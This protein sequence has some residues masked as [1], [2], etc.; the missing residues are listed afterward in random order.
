MRVVV[1]LQSLVEPAA[2]VSTPHTQ[3]TV[4]IPRTALHA[5]RH[6]QS[7]TH[8]PHGAHQ[9]HMP[10]LAHISPEHKHHKKH[11]KKHKKHSHEI[12]A[13][14][15]TL[16]PASHPKIAP[17]R[18]P[19]PKPDPPLSTL[20]TDSS[21]SH[22]PHTTHSKHH[23]H[24]HKR[25]RDSLE[26]QPHG[27]TSAHGTEGFVL[28]KIKRP[29]IEGL[30]FKESQPVEPDK[31]LVTPLQIQLPPEVAHDSGHKHKKKKKK[32]KH[33]KPSGDD[34]SWEIKKDSPQPTPPQVP[35]QPSPSKE[36]T[37][38]APSLKIT[39]IKIA[40]PTAQTSPGKQMRL[41]RGLESSMKEK[42]KSQSLQGDRPSR[43]QSGTGKKVEKPV[44]VV[45]LTPPPPAALVRTKTPQGNCLLDWLITYELSTWPIFLN[46]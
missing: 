3:L 13:H 43:R 9:L 6:H 44:E 34:V 38:M 22:T 1:P 28:P 39:P 8:Q 7:H 32:H 42:A 45:M 12:P 11:K 2:P 41:L 36:P 20:P 19:V 17:I 16:V 46:Q 29:K 24:T 10:P 4:S 15:E 14:S 31:R 26:E 18:L 21:H 35:P 23:K 33:S 37:H 25:S 27:T 5:P 40:P 30:Q